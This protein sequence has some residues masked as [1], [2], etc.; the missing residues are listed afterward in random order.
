M[1]NQVCWKPVEETA[2]GRTIYCG[3]PAK[4]GGDCVGAMQWKIP[5]TNFGPHYNLNWSE[6]STTLWQKIW[7]A[8]EDRTILTLSRKEVDRLGGMLWNIGVFK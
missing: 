3:Q 1:N 8:A 2:N 5:P 4:H 6:E 7:T